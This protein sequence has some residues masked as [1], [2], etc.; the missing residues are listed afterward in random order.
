MNLNEPSTSLSLFVFYAI[1]S[2]QGIQAFQAFALLKY[3]LYDDAVHA[4]R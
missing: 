3:E 1:D 4:V 2:T